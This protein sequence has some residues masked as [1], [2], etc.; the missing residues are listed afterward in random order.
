MSTNQFLKPVTTAYNEHLMI[1]GC[2]TVELAEKYGTP[3]YILDE[4]TIRSVCR[5][6][7]DAFKK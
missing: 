5:D 4:Q 7:K 6:Y 3:L 2:D 1:G